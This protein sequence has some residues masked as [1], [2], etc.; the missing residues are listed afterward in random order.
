[1]QIQLI[2]NA[3]LRLQYAGQQ[4]LTDPYL[5]A[6]FSRPSFTGKSLNPT[7]EL[8]I[9]PEEVIADVD[10]VLVS[11]LHS[12]HFDPA[13]RDLLPK[14]T[15]LLCQVGD[16]TQLADMGFQQVTP[17]TK[18]L[19]WRGITINRISGQHG[20]GDVLDDMGAASGFILQAA[21]EP[22]VYWTGDTVWSDTVAEAIHRYQPQIILTHSCGAVWGKNVLIIMDAAQ[23]VKACQ[24]A[25]ES[26]VIAIHMEALDHATV[27]RAELRQYASEN[28]IKQNQ[29]LIPA[30]GE[31]LQFSR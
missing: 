26:T 13:A 27:T 20:S 8:P 4:L 31:T 22:T 19:V 28:G 23:T 5:A 14:D 15:P 21:S 7:V 24:S 11:H 3:T 10:A 2:R 29:L 18:K 25:P 30:D 6:K 9:P 17:I 1:M 12:D 16:E